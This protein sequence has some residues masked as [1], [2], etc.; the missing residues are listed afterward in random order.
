MRRGIDGSSI[1]VGHHPR[2][3]VPKVPVRIYSP[4][5]FRVRVFIVLEAWYKGVHDN[6]SENI[7]YDN[8]ANNILTLQRLLQFILMLGSELKSEGGRCSW[9]GRLTTS[10]CLGG[11]FPLL[12]FVETHSL[13]MNV[14]NLLRSC[15]IETENRRAPR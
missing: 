8:D 11:R 14:A 5:H 12:I 4:L 10:L 6:T 13:C 7:S 1:R 15:G 9:S 2:A 3:H